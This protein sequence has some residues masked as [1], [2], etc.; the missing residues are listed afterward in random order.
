MAVASGREAWVEGRPDWKQ[1]RGV[2]SKMM[3]CSISFLFGHAT[4]L[5]GS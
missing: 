4:W 3:E 1:A 2:L 5:A